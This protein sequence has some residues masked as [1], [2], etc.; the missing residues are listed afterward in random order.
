MGT[1]VHASPVQSYA[2]LQGCALPLIPWGSAALHHTTS[3]H[4]LGGDMPAWVSPSPSRAL[5]ELH[6]MLLLAV[7]PASIAPCSAALPPG[8]LYCA[9]LPTV[10]PSPW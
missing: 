2:W 6:A 3:S 8:G 1:G 5:R 7:C 9:P 10:P 4:G